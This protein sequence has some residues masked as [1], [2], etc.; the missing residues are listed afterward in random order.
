MRG[1]HS[2]KGA[3]TDCLTAATG[4]LAWQ[5]QTLSAAFIKGIST[6]PVEPGPEDCCMRGC[7]NCVWDVYFEALK[8]HR[9]AEGDKGAVHPAYAAATSI[10]AA[11]EAFAKLERQL[12]AQAQTRDDKEA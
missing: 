3:C 6:A 10:D 1:V 11:M 12:Y 4:I 8:Q 5:S 2:F 7:A 9:K